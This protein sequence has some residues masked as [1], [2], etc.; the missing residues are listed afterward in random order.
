MESYAQFFTEFHHSS[1]VLMQCDN[2]YNLNFFLVCGGKKGAELGN[3]RD[4]KLQ[5]YN[6]FIQGIMIIL[7][8]GDGL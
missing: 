4:F 1:K 2:V 6:P 5:E 3:I 8:T 7:V